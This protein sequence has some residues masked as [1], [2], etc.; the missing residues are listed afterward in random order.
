VGNLLVF[1]MAGKILHIGEK[2]TM[3][4]RLEIFRLHSNVTS[5][6]VSTTT[7][8]VVE[9]ADKIANQGIVPAIDVNRHNAAKEIAE[10]KKAPVANLSAIVGMDVLTADAPAKAVLKPIGELAKVKVVETIAVATPKTATNLVR[11][12]CVPQDIHATVNSTKAMV[13]LEI[14]ANHPKIVPLHAKFQLAN[15]A[16][17]YIHVSP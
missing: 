1:M 5:L 13:Y 11:M 10:A 16:T 3:D 9:I 6:Q 12:V 14:V 7:E 8:N 4:T 17:I 2:A 15:V